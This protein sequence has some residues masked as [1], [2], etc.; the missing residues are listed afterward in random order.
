MK[1]QILKKRCSHA[2]L[3]LSFE[4]VPLWRNDFSK[5]SENC[6]ILCACREIARRIAKDTKKKHS[7]R[8][9]TQTFPTGLMSTNTGTY[10]SRVKRTKQEESATGTKT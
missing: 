4:N 6:N 8:Y 9:R 5:F 10:V 3:I 1:G 7:T 2:C